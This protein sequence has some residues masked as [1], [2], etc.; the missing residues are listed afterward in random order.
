MFDLTK[1]IFI[2]FIIR[3]NRYLISCTKVGDVFF[4]TNNIKYC[5]AYGK[6]I[7]N[8][9]FSN[10]FHNNNFCT[11]VFQN[12]NCLFTLQPSLLPPHFPFFKVSIKLAKHIIWKIRLIC[13]LN[14]IQ[15]HHGTEKENII[16]GPLFRYRWSDGWGW[17]F[18]ERNKGWIDSQ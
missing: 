9:I 8:E 10:S 5:F 1:E 18:I 12:K 6:M 16:D 3:S 7:R 11:I 14:G 15:S 17:W 4:C 13:K 2:S